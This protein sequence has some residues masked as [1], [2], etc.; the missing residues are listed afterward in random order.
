MFW[1][2]KEKEM[3]NKMGAYCDME[4]DNFIEERY[5]T[6]EWKWGRLYFD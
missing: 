1:D 2:I 5:L 4:E 3:L 6:P